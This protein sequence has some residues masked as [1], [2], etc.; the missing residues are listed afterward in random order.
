MVKLRATAPTNAFRMKNGVTTLS[1][2]KQLLKKKIDFFKFYSQFR[3]FLH[4]F[5]HFIRN[6]A[7]FCMISF[8]T[9]WTPVTKQP[10]HVHHD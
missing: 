9:V 4:D 2:G 5:F 1:I 8:K 7:F 10:A 6:L 3:I